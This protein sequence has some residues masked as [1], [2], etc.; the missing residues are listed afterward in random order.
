MVLLPE[1]CSLSDTLHG[2]PTRALQSVRHFDPGLSGCAMS[3]SSEVLP[4]LGSSVHP[5]APAF[6]LAISVR[7]SAAMRLFRVV[8]A[9]LMV[10]APYRLL[11]GLVGPSRFRRRSL[12]VRLP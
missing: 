9:L 1:P 6:S 4:L 7:Q 10:F 12:R 5:S 3:L 8:C 2:T 11:M